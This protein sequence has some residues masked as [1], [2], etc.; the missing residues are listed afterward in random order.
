LRQWKVVN[1]VGPFRAIKYNAR[2][3]TGDA[4]AVFVGNARGF[5]KVPQAVKDLYQFMFRKE[6]APAELDAWLSRGGLQNLFTVAEEV[7]NKQ[8]LKTFW[9]VVNRNG[10]GI[11]LDD[12]NVIK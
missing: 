7:G 10:D 1:L 11:N 8:S 2:N 9:G 3:L 5:T 6:D 12:L 4:D